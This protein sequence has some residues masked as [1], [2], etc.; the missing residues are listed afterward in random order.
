MNESNQRELVSFL[1]ELDERLG[2]QWP[3]RK[4]E[5]YV[6]GGAAAVVAYASKRATVDLDV[7]LENKEVKSKLLEWGG[8]GSKLELK[9]GVYLE[10]ANT[11]LMLIEDPE[12]RERSVEIMHGKFKSM[13]LMA[14]SKEDLILSKLGRY[15]DRDR[16]D[17]QHLIETCKADSEKL[18]SYY[19]SARQYYV[20]NLRTIDATFN[21]VLKE[22]F[23]LGP[24]AF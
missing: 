4:I 3:G 11:T 2:T 5:M 20:G 14:V 8:H 6:F 13:R 9:Y 23:N 10:S 21:I 15:N 22:H 24:I 17:I 18:V 12:W 19:K 1:G 7:F 16:A